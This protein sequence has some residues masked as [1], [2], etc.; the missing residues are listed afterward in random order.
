MK[1][2]LKQDV[3]DVGKKMQ[4]L[5][6]KDGYAQNFLIK[7]KLAVPATDENMKKLEEELAEIAAEEARI[8]AEA[9]DVKAKINLKT[10]VLKTKCGTSG[11]LYGAITNQEVA[12]CIS[13][14]AGVTIDKRK[15]TFDA[16]K[17]V[18]SY[19][20]K[21]KLHPQVEAKVTL[22]VEAIG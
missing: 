17:N 5:E 19:E 9:E 12:D 20:V 13:K 11:K 18:G 22:T 16:I 10:F 7:K 3:E 21:L 6:V 14:A 2:I 4:V 15:V 8:K 1:V